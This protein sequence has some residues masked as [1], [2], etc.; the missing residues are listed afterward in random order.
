MP[1]NTHQRDLVGYGG[2]PPDIVWPNGARVAVSLCVN[3]EEG[4]ELQFGDGDAVCERVGEVTSV[5]GANKRDMGQEQIFAYGTR[6]GL[7]RFLHALNE[8]KTPATF[9]FC[10]KAVERTGSLPQKIVACG[11]EAACHGWR[12]R[13]HT[14]YENSTAEKADLQRCIDTLTAA[15]GERPRGFFC[16]GSESPWTRRILSDLGFC[17]TSNAFDDDM[18]YDD[19]TGL[20]VLPYNLDCNDM[21]FFHPNGFVRADEMLGYVQDALEQLIAEANQGKSSTLS[22][23]FHLR[24]SGRPARFKAF[25]KL[26]GFLHELG[27]QVWVARRIDIARAYQQL[28]PVDNHSGAQTHARKPPIV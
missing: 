6:V 23:G 13:P 11:H 17:Y 18:P 25:T 9:F 20:V 19:A 12:W 27:N 1:D 15:T 7:W 5:V 8:H 28:S 26:L 24:I 14:D 16:R 22:I 4:A 3:F 10:G 21:K 2:N